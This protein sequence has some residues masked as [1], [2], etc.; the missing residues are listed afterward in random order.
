MIRV[1]DSPFAEL[2][3]AVDALLAARLPDGARAHTDVVADL[4]GTLAREMTS[5][6]ERRQTEVR[7]FLQWIEQEMQCHIDDLAGKTTLL[8][9]WSAENPAAAVL[10]VLERNHPRHVPVSVKRPR[11][12]GANNAARSRVTDAVA[13]S[14]EVLAP[15]LTR[16]A[17][18]DGLI[19]E[20]VYRMYALSDAEIALVE[21]SSPA[22]GGEAS[23]VAAQLTAVTE[24]PSGDD[25]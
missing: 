21:G 3:D 1:A 10:N 23:N 11:A 15:I 2:L 4:L 9:Y 19:D 25:P 7:D 20:L 22:V 24:R 8:E 17:L 5:L 14:M 13:R 16:L 18:T 12:Y 6:H